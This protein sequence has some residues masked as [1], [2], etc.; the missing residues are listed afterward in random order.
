M[1]DSRIDISKA[2]DAAGEEVAKERALGA[3]AQEAK[4]ESQFFRHSDP[5][6]HLRERRLDLGWIGRVFG[7]KEEKAGNVAVAAIFLAF[8]MVITMTIIDASVADAKI[9]YS[10]VVVTGGISIITAALGYVCGVDSSSN[11]QKPD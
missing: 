11:S 6:S 4:Q 1:S 5:E 8:V 3:A 2:Q 10:Q 9:P 7:G